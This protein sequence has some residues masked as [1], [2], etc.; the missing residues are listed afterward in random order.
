MKNLL[1]YHKLFFLLRFLMIIVAGS[2]NMYGIY[3]M[4]TA[5]PDW[6]FY[7]QISIL[8]LFAVIIFSFLSDLF[9]KRLLDKSMAIFLKEKDMEDAEV[10]KK[11]EGKQ[12]L[13]KDEVFY[14]LE[15]GINDNSI[16]FILS[17]AL[18]EWDAYV[19]LEDGKID[20]KQL[21]FLAG[22]ESPSWKETKEIN[23]LENEL[24]EDDEKTV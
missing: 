18:V 20:K 21:S 23:S 5:Q 3:L 9:K 19:V 12:L 7:L 4:A 22:W 11:I 8:F 10:V 24:T 6:S 2:I 14:S 16:A 1:K 13:K 17:P 15:Y